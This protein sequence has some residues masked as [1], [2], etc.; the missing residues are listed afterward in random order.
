MT[1]LINLKTPY[2]HLPIRSF[3]SFFW[4]KAKLLIKKKLEYLKK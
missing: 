2:E 3:K 1:N 4:V